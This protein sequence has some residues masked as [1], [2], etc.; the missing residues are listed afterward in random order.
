MS[1]G[2][3][4][5]QVALPVPLRRTFDYLVP[6]RD[7]GA[8][9]PG[10]RV[11]VPL[12]TRQVV[13]VVVGIGASTD[14]DAE[15]LRPAIALVDDDPI[16]GPDE[17]WLIS[18]AS[19]YYQHPVGEVAAAALPSLL[20]R[21]RTRSTSG[22][23]QRRFRIVSAAGG[24]PHS[25]G[26][27]QRDL[28]AALTAA[29][30]FGL[31]RAELETTVGGAAG[32]LHRLVARGLV[33]VFEA[34]NEVAPAGTKSPASELNEWQSAAVM[35]VAG[36]AP[37]YDAYLLEGVTG[38]G[39]T[40]VYLQLVERVL[41]LGG[42]ALVLIPE[43]GLTRQTVA[44]F[45]DRLHGKLAVYHSALSASEREQAWWDAR[46]GTA[47]VVLGTR[48]AIW[49]PMPKLGIVIVDEEHDASYKQQEGLRYS[50]RDMGVVRARRAKVPIVLGSATPSLES[51]LNVDR[52][53]YRKL[54]L[55]QRTAAAGP[56]SIEL[57]D[58][59]RQPMQ[60]ALSRILVDAMRTCLEARQQSLLFV[61]RRGFS[62]LLLCQDCGWS[63]KCTQCSSRLVLHAARN[64]LKCHYCGYSTAPP[65]HCPD[66]SGIALAKLGHGT[67]RVEE[68]VR[69]CFPE[70]R[71][72]R[73][74][75]DSTRRRGSMDSMLAAIDRGDADILVGTQMLAKGHHLPNVTLVGVIHADTG[76]Q[77]FD[78]R[79]QERLAQ[80][81]TQVTGRAGRAQLAG[82]VL[83]QTYWPEDPLLRVLLTEGYAAFARMALAERR[84]AHLPPFQ[85]IALLR[86]ESRGVDDWRHFLE[87]CVGLAQPLPESVQVLGPVE[88]PMARRDGRYRGQVLVDS[89]SRAALQNF[90]GG[91]MRLVEGAQ[92]GRQVRWSIDVDPMEMS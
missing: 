45:R 2:G 81:L 89:S 88:A 84:A 61:N 14:V 15:R 35:T 77:G 22:Q 64:R 6:D 12:G 38:S 39:K 24:M 8:L 91:W 55:P 76:R 31:A 17:L 69:Q 4:V 18:W 53:R 11:L 80:L 32:P 44:R 71:V 42:Q 86:A 83:I 54:E 58:L 75:S 16:L 10:R 29:G 49:M 56:P 92:R 52:Q 67:E 74:D 9:A 5:L 41:A 48:S 25:L 85:F 78:F 72:L 23:S 20:R 70:A 46:S 62:P 66:C 13:G 3:P 1:V 82:R 43:I 21:A 34:S 73:V 36:A 79:S 30:Q 7:P 47:R 19:R 40:E 51:L 33:E 60:G 59:R 57:I 68:T 87:N 37:G 28:W 65:S 27:V 90:L 63:A 50:A 26:R